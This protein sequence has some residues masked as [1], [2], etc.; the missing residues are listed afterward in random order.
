MRWMQGLW[1]EQIVVHPIP[2][3]F[4]GNYCGW[5][6]PTPVDRWFGP[7]LFFFGGELWEKQDIGWSDDSDYR[8]V[9]WPLLAGGS[10]SLKIENLG[11]LKQGRLLDSRFGGA[12]D[13]SRLLVTVTLASNHM[14][15]GG[16]LTGNIGKPFQLAKKRWC[17]ALHIFRHQ[18]YCWYN[19]W[20]LNGY[21]VLVAI[22]SNN[23]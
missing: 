2:Q 23:G 1:F 7:L 18:L 22:N 17:P 11:I 16:K 8:S 15:W 3:F 19:K 10:I 20:V 13:S 12:W 4:E 21:W 6:N 14:R 9:S 5:K